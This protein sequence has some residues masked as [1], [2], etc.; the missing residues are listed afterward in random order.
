MQQQKVDVTFPLEEGGQGSVRFSLEP[1][2][3]ELRSAFGTAHSLTTQRTNALITIQ[4]GDSKNTFIGYGEVGLPPKKPHCYKA[5]YN[6]VVVYFQRFVSD[7]SQQLNVWNKKAPYDPFQSLPERYFAPLRQ[8]QEGK[9]GLNNSENVIR[10]LFELLDRCILNGE[11]FACAAISGIE[12]ALFDL[13]G[14][15]RQQSVYMLL[16]FPACN[17][18]SFYTVAMAQTIGPMLE[19]ADRLSGSITQHSLNSK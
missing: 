16:G 7:V 2:I 17:A 13:W 11:S 8:P 15:I 12:M 10:F 19:S 3:L 6:D 14:K 9:D 1:Y 4:L 5:D 18:H